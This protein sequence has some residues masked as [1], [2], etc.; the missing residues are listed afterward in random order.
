MLARALVVAACAVSLG[1]FR[2]AGAEGESLKVELA[3]IASSTGY[4]TFSLY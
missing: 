4:L 3:L 1:N 2:I